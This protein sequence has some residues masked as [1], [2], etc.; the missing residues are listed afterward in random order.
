MKKFACLML[1][2]SLVL[3]SASL[4]FAQEKKDDTKTETKKDSKKKAAP[5]KDEK[6]DETKKAAPKKDEKK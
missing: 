6:T 1:G 5:K 3:G 4:T 2:L